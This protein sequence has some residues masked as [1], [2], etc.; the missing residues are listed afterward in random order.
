VRNLSL[1][2]NFSFPLVAIRI[3]FFIKWFGLP[4]KGQSKPA[5][6]GV[7]VGPPQCTLPVS[8]RQAFREKPN[9]GIGL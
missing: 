3:T 7:K 4:I 6:E 1:A 9:E 5:A 2:D 8:I